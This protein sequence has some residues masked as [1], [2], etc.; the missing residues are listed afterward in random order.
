[1]LDL[2]VRFLKLL[3]YMP[4]NG[5]L[6]IPS[7]I[8]CSQSGVPTVIAKKIDNI[9][10]KLLSDNPFSALNLNSFSV[11]VNFV[12]SFLQFGYNCT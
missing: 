1:M 6:R 5:I 11:D 3:Q 7:L 2:T 9:F 4:S 8:S 10:V 12:C